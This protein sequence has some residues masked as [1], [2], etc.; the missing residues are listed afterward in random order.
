M[1]EGFAGPTLDAVGEGEAAAPTAVHARSPLKVIASLEDSPFE[2]A[3][4]VIDYVKGLDE[5][6][7]GILRA[8]TPAALSLVAQNGAEWAELV[9]SVSN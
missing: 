7:R 8:A 2:Q 3:V 9:N 6:K 4:K 1:S 5:R